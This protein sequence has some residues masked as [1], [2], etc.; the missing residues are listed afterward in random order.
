MK[1]V[2]FALSVV[3]TAVAGSVFAQEQPVGCAFSITTSPAENTQNE[4]NFSWATDKDTHSASLEIT[5]L[6]DKTWKKSRTQV[7]EGVLCTV[8]DSLYSKT[9]DGKNFYEDVEINKYNA[10]V[11]GLKKNTEYKYR[12]IAADTSEVYHFRTAGSK[13]WS[14]SIISDF[15]AYAPLYKR[16]QSAM[17]MMKTIGSY[18]QPYQ[19]VLHLGDVTAW[20]GSYS[21]WRELYKEEPFKQYMWAGVN[22]N[23]DN[24][25]RTNKG[26]SNQFFRQT[27]AYPLNGYKGEEGVCY[28]FY[29]GDVL[30]IMLNNE[31]MRSDEGL[32]AAQQWVRKV[33]AENPA[34]YR[35]VCEHYQ[36]FFGT[37]GKES[38]YARWNRLFDELGIDLA[39]SGNNHIYV[40]THPL[41]D[42]KVVD[43]GQGTVYIQTPSSDNERGQALVSSEAP[44][45]NADK[46]KFRWNEGPQT[47]GGM[48][49]K[50][51]KKQ[52]TLTLL[53]RN[54]KVLD[55][56]VVKAKKR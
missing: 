5:T 29:Y 14:A 42:G 18:D 34:R 9:P 26:N 30:F 53:D 56:N 46:I 50:V 33:V 43:S 7:V 12:I 23:H 22:G 10:S 51:T 40:S 47:I 17:E 25:T 2:L 44:E 36:W 27:A 49:M 52:L 4:M 6:K 19:W 45:H 39:L 35:V 24:M 32:Q 13:N 37:N 41:Y 8:F 21:F 48:H 1:R 31:N 11:S 20:G 15:H 54:G 3:V 28:Y 55:V 16:T 38:Q